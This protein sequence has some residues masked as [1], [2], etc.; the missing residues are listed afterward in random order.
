MIS[1]FILSILFTLFPKC[2]CSQTGGWKY[3]I[4]NSLWWIQS[5]VSTRARGLMIVFT[6]SSHGHP[7]EAATSSLHEADSHL[8]FKFSRG[9]KPSSPQASLKLLSGWSLT[10]AAIRTHQPITFPFFF[11]SMSTVLPSQSLCPGV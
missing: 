5:E 10:L 7:W 4:Y 2:S 6:G 11:Y 8:S 3:W 1:L 9:P